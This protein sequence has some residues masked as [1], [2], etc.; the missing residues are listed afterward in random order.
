MEPVIGYYLQ[1]SSNE[2]HI[3]P[4]LAD[5]TA[6]NACWTGIIFTF[7][8]LNSFYLCHLRKNQLRAKNSELFI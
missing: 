6:Q 1:I 4:P 8:F 2:W 7:L 5:Q 3:L